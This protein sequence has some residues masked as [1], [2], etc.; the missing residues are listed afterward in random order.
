[1][2]IPADDGA[3]IML[4]AIEFGKAST[5][6][7]LSYTHLNLIGGDHYYIWC[8]LN[9][10]EKGFTIEDLDTKKEYYVTSSTLGVNKDKGT[11]IKLA[12]TIKFKVYLPVI[13]DNIKQ[14]SIYGCGK[15][16]GR[17]QFKDIDLEKYKA[18]VNVNFEDYT[19]DFAL[20][21]LREGYFADS[22]SL[23]VELVE[24]NP[25][26]VIAL[27]TLGILSY[28][29]DN[30]SDAIYYFSEAIDKNPNDDLAYVNRFAVYKYQSNYSAAL[31]DITKAI[32]VA[33][34]QPDHYIYRGMLYMDLEDWKNAKADFDKAL[35]SEDFKKD[36][37]GYYY[38]TYVN[39]YLGNWKEACKDIYTAFNLTDSKEIEKELRVLWDKCGCNRY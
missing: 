12:S 19:R 4:N 10:K 33:P 17:W 31:E 15:D 6:L 1:L 27:N 36:A 28:V 13:K 16:D 8:G 38:R 26:D 24:N 21:S 5:T 9:K 32:S 37:I 23:L 35:E 34:D 29:S 25:D 39:A 11:E 3:S 7:Y 22:H 18:K 30:N 14:I 2:N 20:A